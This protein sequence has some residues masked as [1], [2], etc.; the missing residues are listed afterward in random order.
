MT[1][2]TA[3]VMQVKIN[4]VSCGK[5]AAASGAPDMPFGFVV[6]PNEA[7]SINLVAGTFAINQWVEAI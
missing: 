1:N 4:G 6:M 2:G 3:G 7:Y 5:Y